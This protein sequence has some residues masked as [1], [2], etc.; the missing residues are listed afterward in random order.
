MPPTVLIASMMRGREK[1][2]LDY[3]PSYFND[4]VF[5]AGFVTGFASAAVIFRSLYKLT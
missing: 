5:I 2:L 4:P 3:F 1:S